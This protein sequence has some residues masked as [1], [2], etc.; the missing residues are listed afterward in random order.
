M[1]KKIIQQ[2]KLNKSFLVTSHINLEGDAIGSILAMR[3]ILLHFKKKV[4]VVIQDE[5][6]PEY[7]FLPDI[8]CIKTLKDIKFND[9]DVLVL[10]DVSDQKRCQKIINRFPKD[11]TTISIDHHIS[12]SRF[13]KINWIEPKVSSTVEMIYKLY[14]R[15]NIPLNRKRALWLYTGLLTDTGSF[16]YPNTTAY[17]FKLAG[18]L[19][20][21]G[22][23]VSEI[24][25]NI[26][27]NLSLKEL[28]IINQ[29]LSTIRSDKKNRIVWFKMKKD[30]FMKDKSTRDFSDVILDMGRS[31]KDIEV[32]VL[33]KEDFYNKDK[34]HV[35]LRS[36]NKVDVD[37]I[38]RYFG[39]G[40]HRTA[41]GCDIKD[42]L[43]RAEKIVIRRIKECIN[44][45]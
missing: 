19:L 18:K 22:L 9:Y 38:A 36:K 32:V 7:K 14:K 4:E 33:F 21:C 25:Q 24:Y 39:G 23:N 10:L 31:I 41:S 1:I 2:I 34:I 6:P 40:G 42:N 11:K 28:K 12:N 30:F 29:I 15:L 27:Y 26:Y 16:R 45:K 37:M 13:A 43:E 8:D 44:K 35:S 5:I 20:D 3:D 17:S